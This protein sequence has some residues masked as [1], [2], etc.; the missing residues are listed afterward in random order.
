MMACSDCG[1]VFRVVADSLREVLKAFRAH[2]KRD[3]PT[4]RSNARE[5]AKELDRSLAGQQPNPTKQ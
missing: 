2:I 1:A 4:I 5:L 3:H